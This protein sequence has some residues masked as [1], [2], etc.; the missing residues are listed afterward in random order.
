MAYKSSKHRNVTQLTLTFNGGLNAAQ[1]GTNIGDNQLQIC[2]N[3]VYA[4]NQDFPTVRNGVVLNGVAPITEDGENVPIDKLHYYV[5]DASTS[6]LVAAIGGNLY[7]LDGSSWSLIGALNSV[8]VI[9]CMLTYGGKLIVAD[10]GTSL[11]YWDGTTFST[12]SGSPQ[13][14]TALA[15]IGGRLVSNSKGT[16]EWDGVFFQ[17]LRRNGLG[18]KQWGHHCS[19]RLQRRPERRGIWRHGN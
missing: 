19:R 4:N 18:S 17:D 14:A 5:K 1:S 3:F 6:W 11:K 16:G 10:G 7:W 15:E 8:G 12:I 13:Y 2:S 9:P